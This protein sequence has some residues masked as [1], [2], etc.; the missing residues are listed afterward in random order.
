M[1]AERTRYSPGFL[2]HHQ[3]WSTRLRHERV[4]ALRLGRFY[5]CEVTRPGVDQIEP[6]PSVHGGGETAAPF[7]VDD[8]RVDA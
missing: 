2:R 3:F 8:G 5:V 4:C 1:L 7:A 6:I